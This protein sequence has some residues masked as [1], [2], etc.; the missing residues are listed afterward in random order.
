MVRSEDVAG[1]N[2]YDWDE[3]CKRAEYLHDSSLS[4]LEGERRAWNIP[5]MNL[6][7]AGDVVTGEDIYKGQG[8]DIDRILLEQTLD[9]SE[10]FVQQL[11]KPYLEFF[12]TVRMYGT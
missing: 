4:I 10:L 11:I 6:L 8:R 5:A 7:F 3:L 12:P 9:V 2:A 1:L